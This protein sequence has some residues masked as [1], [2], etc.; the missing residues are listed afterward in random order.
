[1]V[2]AETARKLRGRFILDDLGLH[3]LRGFTAPVQAFRALAELPRSARLQRG[4][5]RL[6]GFVGRRSS[7][8]SCMRAGRRRSPATVEW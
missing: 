5:P 8:P 4:A 3:T 1:V 2:A 6:A 7:W